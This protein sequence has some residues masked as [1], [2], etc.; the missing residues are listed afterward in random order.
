MPNSAP[1][2]CLG[3]CGRRVRA[4]RCPG[5]S[6]RTNQTRREGRGF[7]YSASWWRKWRLS[8]LAQFVAQHIPPVCGA[9]LPGGPSNH[10]SQCWQAGRRYTGTSAD[11]S[12]LHL[13]HEPE[14]SQAE[15]DAIK[16]GHRS[17][18]CDEQRIV[19]AC[20]ECHSAETQRGRQRSAA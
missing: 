7:D 5:C 8:L 6:H 2:P 1:R 3:G 9:T 19:L 16:A 15:L 11:G 17:I 13:H 20:R 10:V 12:S 14:L 4:G 18:A